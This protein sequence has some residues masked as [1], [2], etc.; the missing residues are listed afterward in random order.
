MFSMMM[1]VPTPACGKGGIFSDLVNV[2]ARDCISTLNI[3]FVP[4]PLGVNLF[5]YTL[6][7]STVLLHTLI[8]F[9]VS[10]L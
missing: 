1:M 10:L 8:V 7:F 5:H 6:K 2:C 9:I 3:C 4:F